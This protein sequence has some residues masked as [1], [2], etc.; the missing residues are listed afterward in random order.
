M[1]QTKRKG[2]IRI[3]LLKTICSDINTDVSIFFS[4]YILGIPIHFEYKNK[5]SSKSIGGS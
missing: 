3:L 1:G 5:K 4:C 2:Y